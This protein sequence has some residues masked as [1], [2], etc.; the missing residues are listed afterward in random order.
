[1]KTVKTAN[2]ELQILNLSTGNAKLKS[3]KA[4]KFLIWNLP[5]ISTCPN[6]TELCKSICYARKSERLYPS[7]LPCREQNLIDAN[8]SS[9]LSDMVRTIKFYLDKNSFKQA[10][11]VY[12]RFHE[13]GDFYSQQYFNDCVIIASLFPQVTFLAYSKSLQFY[14][15]SVYRNILPANFIFRYSVMSDTAETE[16][17]TAK[18]LNLP[19][20][21][22]IKKGSS[23]KGYFKCNC[24]DCGTC[25]LCY[26][27]DAVKIACE[28]H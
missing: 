27:K 22:A 11:K 18:L 17:E 6:A 7:V 3:S 21:T 13:S 28:I 5:A 8:S 16:T 26:K 4:V 15:N 9:F 20:Y 12:F 24:I 2:T 19:I 1:M 25:Q 14:K 23:F 10:D